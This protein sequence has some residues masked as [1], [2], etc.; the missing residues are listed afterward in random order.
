MR[1]KVYP[2][3]RRGRRLPWRDVRNGPA[4]VGELLSRFIDHGGYRYHVLTLA[5]GAPMEQPLME[6]Y[7]P[8]LLTMAP[9]AFRVRGFERVEV[10]QGYTVLQEWHVETP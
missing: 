7:E 5:S 10:G 4:Q 8:V 9:L 1:F 3:R 2:L 6:L